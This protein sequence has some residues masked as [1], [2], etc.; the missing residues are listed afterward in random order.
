[1]KKNRLLKVLVCA[2]LAGTLML[3]GCASTNLDAPCDNF[4]QNCDP[5]ISINQWTPSK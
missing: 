1:M 4:G 5:K 3:Q 2:A